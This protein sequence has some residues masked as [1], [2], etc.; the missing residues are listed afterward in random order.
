MRTLL[1]CGA[2]PNNWSHEA[3]M[4]ASSLPIACQYWLDIAQ[5]IYRTPPTT[6]MTR[7]RL[8]ELS[9]EELV[10]ILL[11]ITGQRLASQLLFDKVLCHRVHSSRACGTLGVPL[12][13]LFAGPPGH[14][15]TVLSER[16]ATAIA[17]GRS[18]KIPC[19]QHK[20]TYAMFGAYAPYQGSEKGSLLNNFLCDNDDSSIRVVLLDEFDKTESEVVDGLLNVFDR[21][22]YFDRS[23]RKVTCRNVTTCRNG[24]VPQRHLHPDGQLPRHA[25]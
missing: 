1:A 4:R 5:Q 22:E 15:K 2:I 11:S 8:K 7:H 14:G 13:L 17:D 12:V 24:H 21:A 9:L 6:K 20:D 3:E 16:L 23:G 19:E 10:Q 25:H 18:Q